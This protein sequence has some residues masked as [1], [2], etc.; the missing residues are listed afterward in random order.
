MAKKSNQTIRIEIDP[1][2]YQK[3]RKKMGPE[4]LEGYYNYTRKSAHVFKDKTK[5]DRKS[6][7]ERKWR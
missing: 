2:D 1:V 3:K 6:K 5:Y 4:E 7:Q